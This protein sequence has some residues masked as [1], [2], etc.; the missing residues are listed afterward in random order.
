MY[1]TDVFINE[2]LTVVVPVYNTAQYLEKCINSIIYQKYNKLD[3]ILINDGSTDDSGKFCDEFSNKDDRIRVIHI[4]NNG[5]VA[6]RNLGVQLAYGKL[7]TFVDSDDWIEPDMYFCMMAAYA[8]YNPD[9]IT[10]G[11][12]IETPKNVIY[13]IDKIPPGLYE[14]EDINDK[15]IPCMMYDMQ[16]KQRAITPSMSNKIYKVELLKKVCADLDENIVLGDDAAI[17]YIFITKA[18]KIMILDRSWYHYVARSNS[19]TQNNNIDSFQKI[20]KFYHYMRKKFLEFGI[21]SQTETQVK[22]YTK[23]FLFWAIKSVFDILPERPKYLF[24]FE[25]IE[26]DSS[27]V[28][29]GGGNVGASYEENLIKSRYAKLHG[30]VDQNYTNLMTEDHIIQSPDILRDMEFDYVVIAVKN[31]KTVLEIKENL[32]ELGINEQKVVW[33]SPICLE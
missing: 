13:E 9:M 30:W 31:E 14:C 16:T 11:L 8:E 2:L 6:A 5:P 15:I 17:T 3:I 33:K 1:N 7:I 26:K 24:P 18:T 32:K 12:T 29:Y 10:S 25:L 21:W 27:V 28:I 20:Y 23:I 19:L 4:N 22:A